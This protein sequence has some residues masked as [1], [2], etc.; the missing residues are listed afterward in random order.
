MEQSD[1]LLPDRR[2]LK[3]ASPS[4][5]EQRVMQARFRELKKLVNL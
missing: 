4:Q 3:R 2:Q 5:G 1:S